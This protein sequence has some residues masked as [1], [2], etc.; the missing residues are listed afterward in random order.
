MP[1]RKSRTASEAVTVAFPQALPVRRETAEVWWVTLPE[2]E[3]R[4]SNLTK[5]F[6]PEEGYTKGDLLAYYFNVAHLLLPHLERRPLTMKR[7]PNGMDGE[8]FY[9]KTAPSH[10]PDWVHRCTVLSEDAKEGRIDYLTI[11]DLSTLLFVANLGAIE[12]HPLHSRCGDTE[13]PD[14]LFFDL[15]PFP[16]YTYEDVLTVARHVKVVLD[17]LGLTGYPKTS[18]ATGL[19]IYVP[20]E[21]GRWTYGEVRAFVGACGRMIGRA[22]PD[23]V[24]MA[25]RIADRT[26]KIFIDHNMNRQGANIA[27]AYSLR[28]ELRAPVSTPLTWDEVAAGGFEPQDF[29]IDNVWERFAEVGDRW[30]PVREGPYN[31]LAPAMEALGVEPE[32]DPSGPLPRTAS[33]AVAAKSRMR[34]R[35]RRRTRPC[36]STSGG[37]SSVRRERR[38]RR[39]AR[40]SA[41]AT[42][43]VIHK[44]RATRLH[45]DVRLE[46]DGGCPRGRS[47]RASRPPRATN[48]WR[49][50][51]RSTRSNTG[52]SRAPSPKA[53]TEPAR[54]ASS[55]TGG[56]SR[57]SGP[58]RRSRSG[59]TGGGTRTSSSTSSRH[60]RTGSRSSRARR[61]PR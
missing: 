19:Q 26:G 45:Y 4:L 14:Y 57:W 61:P 32:E 7:M 42:S 15:D 43:F 44:H 49:S 27:A 23:R 10:T 51:P 29:R 40:T 22:D 47:P 17:Q 56:T 35:S 31:D 24:T 52:S 50:T 21:A 34:S 28:P 39:R 18:G 2:R 9:E 48:A 53:T 12:M 46:H 33:S 8:S 58:T 16:P 30:A 37:A 36:S 38:S 20:I 55:T 25:W 13:H 3:L 59:S 41:P 54:C 1:K 60:G 6:W 11:D 5:I